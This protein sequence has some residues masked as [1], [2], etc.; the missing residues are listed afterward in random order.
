VSRLYNNQTEMLYDHPEW[1]NR[2]T[3]FGSQ[4]PNGHAYRNRSFGRMPMTA[5]MICD[6]GTYG[7]NV[8]RDFSPTPQ[9][10]SAVFSAI[11]E[12]A[13]AGATKT[14]ELFAWGDNFCDH[15]WTNDA[16]YEVNAIDYDGSPKARISGSW[17]CDAMGGIGG[18]ASDLSQYTPSNCGNTDHMPAYVELYVRGDESELPGQGGTV[19]K[20]SAYGILAANGNFA[21]MI[22]GN[23]LSTA[24]SPSSLWNHLV[25]SYKKSDGSFKLY[26]NGSLRQSKTLTAGTAIP[27]NTSNLII[28][29]PVLAEMDEVSIY[30]SALTD[31]EIKQRYN[32][33]SRGLLARWKLDSGYGGTA[34]DDGSHEKHIPLKNGP[35]WQ[36]STINTQFQNWEAIGNALKFDGNNDYLD[37]SGLNLL[38]DEGT[39]SMWVRP[40]Y[41]DDL[42]IDDEILFSDGGVENN[43]N[44]INFRDRVG[45]GS[46]N[47]KIFYICNSTCSNYT[48]CLGTEWDNT[49]WKA[50]TWYL[51]TVTWDLATIDGKSFA[52][53]YNNGQR[54]SYSEK[55]TPYTGVTFPNVLYLGGHGGTSAF[56]GS[57]DDIE[58][59][60]RPLDVWEIRRK[61]ENYSWSLTGR[62]NFDESSGTVLRDSAN[63]GNDLTMVNAVRATST[64]GAAQFGASTGNMLSMDGNGDYAYGPDSSGRL[65][66]NGGNRTMTA[67]IYQTVNSQDRIVGVFAAQGSDIPQYGTLLSSG[68]IRVELHNGTSYFCNAYSNTSYATNTWQHIAAVFDGSKLQFYLNGQPDGATSC[69][70]SLRRDSAPYVYIG[71]RGD[72]YSAEYFTGYIEDVAIYNKALGA[73][74]IFY[75]AN[76]IRQSGAPLAKIDSPANDASA[77]INSPI[78][79]TATSSS[80]LY[81]QNKGI[82]S[83]F[84]DFNDGTPILK[85]GSS[86]VVTYA[87]PGLKAVKLW[88]VDLDGN[89]SNLSLGNGLIYLNITPTTSLFD[90]LATVKKKR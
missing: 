89:P 20:G 28:A 47:D 13:C 49:V 51:L 39:I 21:G 6:E 43:T 33:Y 2:G 68:K 4:T 11:P 16:T 27:V 65:S 37:A 12:A 58:I 77:V 72:L 31:D 40:T 55:T 35:T 71:S 52:A 18:S 38:G 59:Y 24:I 22:G 84:W 34:Y 48:C 7:C 23:W 76:F 42:R 66:G 46:P 19:R 75:Q 81:G 10:L 88:V 74:E 8:D 78:T 86:V 44:S 85:R 56:D 82:A 45:G 50:G 67:W 29:S 54:V 69:V 62:W 70:G 73:Q 90:R 79:F 32:L 1:T 26:V 36:A 53:I 9:P 64:L 14:M 83:Y 87:T 3:E 80:D 5:L 57:I 25:M 63:E 30:R 17:H 41:A 61:Y 15:F 60:N